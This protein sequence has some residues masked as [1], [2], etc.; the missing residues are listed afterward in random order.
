MAGTIPVEVYLFP[1][2]WN[3]NEKE[4]LWKEIAGMGTCPGSWYDSGSC[5]GTKRS[6]GSKN[7][8]C[9]GWRDNRSSKNR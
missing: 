9:L 2:R 7:Y 1:V 5:H 3:Q 4:K 6:T 8:E